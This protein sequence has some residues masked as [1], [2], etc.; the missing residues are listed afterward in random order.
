MLIFFNGKNRENDTDLQIL[1]L[2]IF[3]SRKKKLLIF[4]INNSWKRS[5]FVFF[6]V[7]LISQNLFT[8]FYV[9]KSWKRSGFVHLFWQLWFPGKMQIF[10]MEKFRENGADL[11]ILLLTTLI[12]RE[13][14]EF[15]NGKISWKR[16][17]FAQFSW[18]QLW[19]TKKNQGNNSWKR[20]DDFLGKIK[21]N[22]SW[23]RFNLHI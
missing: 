3:I 7:T 9:E 17:G 16:S 6:F 13:K 12:S 23:K 11:H 8:I 18:W 21:V 1:L 5:R 15:S 22:K 10:L 19:F 14:C 20:C 2:T 4:S